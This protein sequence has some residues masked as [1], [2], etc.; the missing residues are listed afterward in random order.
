MGGMRLSRPSV[1]QV[2]V[3]LSAALLPGGAMPAARPHR[4]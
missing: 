2:L 4:L 3:W 1:T